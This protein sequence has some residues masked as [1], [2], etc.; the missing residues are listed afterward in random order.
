MT[1]VV[2]NDT[3]LVLY[4]LVAELDLV[5]KTKIGNGTTYIAIDTSERYL[6]DAEHKV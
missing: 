2:T 1:T 5:D 6:F 4:G 3:C